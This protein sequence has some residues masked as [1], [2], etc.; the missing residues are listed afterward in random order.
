MEGT[1]WSFPVQIVKEDTIFLSLR[2]HD[3][4]RTFL[5]TE[6]RGCEEGSRFIIVFRLGSTPGPIGC[7]YTGVDIHVSAFVHMMLNSCL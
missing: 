3:G 7:F 4:S 1:S 6:I 5:R 2:R